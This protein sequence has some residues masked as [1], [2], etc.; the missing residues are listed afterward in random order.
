MSVAQEDTD[1]LPLSM[2][3]RS[4]IVRATERRNGPFRLRDNDDNVKHRK[5]SG[6]YCSNPKLN[7]V[8]KISNSEH[9]WLNANV[10]MVA[11]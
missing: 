6:H 5:R 1:A 7:E 3:R 8:S 4:E 11:D 2:L 10:R 9:P